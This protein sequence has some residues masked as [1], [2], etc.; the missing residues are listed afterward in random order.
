MSIK[1]VRS[2]TLGIRPAKRL[3]QQFCVR[4]WQGLRGGTSPGPNSEL[5]RNFTFSSPGGTSTTIPQVNITPY[6][7]AGGLGSSLGYQFQFDLTGGS[8]VSFGGIWGA[9]VVP[10][11]SALALAGLSG[12][13]LL[14]RRRRK[15]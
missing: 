13:N 4:L 2:S 3:R 9:N 14:V 7:V 5:L 11:P 15:I 10:A 6:T 1:L 12:V 8:T